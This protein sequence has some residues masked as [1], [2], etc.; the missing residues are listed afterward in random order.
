[1]SVDAASECRLR[2]DRQ[3]YFSIT[4]SLVQ[5]QFKLDDRELS[6][7]LWQEVADRDLDVSR[8]INLMYG[9]WFHQDEDEM[10]EVDNRH[11]SLFVD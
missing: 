3:S 7:R 11:L 9:C 4:R 10:I 5:A 6:R 2:N 1:M 8:I